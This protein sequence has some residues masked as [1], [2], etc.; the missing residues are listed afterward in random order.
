MTE[1]LYKAEFR[2]EP[3][4]TLQGSTPQAREF[5]SW[6]LAQQNLKGRVGEWLADHDRSD[7]LVNIY[8]DDVPGHMTV[9]LNDRTTALMLKLALG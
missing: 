9:V 8:T 1:Q 6:Y 2:I 4:P 7:H 5:M 3:I